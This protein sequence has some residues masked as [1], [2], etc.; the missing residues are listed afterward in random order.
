MPGKNRVTEEGNSVPSLL[1]RRESG[2][3]IRLTIEGKTHLV[4]DDKSFAALLDLVE[5]LE[6]LEGI[7]AGLEDA[8]AGRT[9]PV[10]E[11]FEELRPKVERREA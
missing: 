3:P 1:R 2:E 11:F 8:D 5:R 10:E 9:R 6:T 4:K 7:R